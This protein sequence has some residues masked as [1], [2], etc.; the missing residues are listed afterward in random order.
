MSTPAVGSTVTVGRIDYEVVRHGC[1][2]GWT[3]CPH[4]DKAV[5]VRRLVGCQMTECYGADRLAPG[6]DRQR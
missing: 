2:T 1:A 5:T 4:G 3:E 6:N